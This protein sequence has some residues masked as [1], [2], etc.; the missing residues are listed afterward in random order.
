MPNWLTTQRACPIGIDFC[1]SGAKL[2]QLRRGRNGFSL[3]DTARID[4]PLYQEA[5]PPT[6]ARLEDLCDAIKR[7]IETERFIGRKCVLAVENRFLRV[8]SVRQPSMPPD[9]LRRAIT[10]EAHSR[11]GFGEGEE[12]QF[13]W[14]TAGEVT[15]GEARGQEVI[16]VGARTDPIQRMVM[17]LARRGLIAVAVEPAF[18]GCA[19]CFTRFIRRASEQQDVHAVVDIGLHST[20][21]MLLR[22]KNIAFYK[23]L[24]F[25][26]EKMA[27]SAAERL[28]LDLEAVRELRLQQLRAGS[29]SGITPDP[30]VDRAIFEGVRPLIG[31]LAREVA[32]CIRYYSVTFRGSR[33]RACM[34]VGG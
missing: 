27:K 23:P 8:R 19:R 6:S 30:K 29:G 15:Q 2:V 28:G 34:V 11:L 21:V 32:L 12:S 20:G 5:E 26:G 7:T 4:M 9:E 33:P 14:L 24:E 25:G 22:G 17:A 3:I 1:A 31:D 16:L 10:L 18:V 13:G